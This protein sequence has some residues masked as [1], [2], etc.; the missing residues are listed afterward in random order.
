MIIEAGDGQLG[1]IRIGPGV[2][3]GKL[4]A[5]VCRSPGPEERCRTGMMEVRIVQHREA[6]IPEQIRPDV[7]MMGGI[8]DLIN[9]QVIGLYA[10]PPD[11]LVRR[12]FARPRLGGSRAGRIDVH[13]Y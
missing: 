10:M 7:I 5:V 3:G 4:R 2:I 13:I 12:A 11:E 8:A 6:R 1:Q 9:H